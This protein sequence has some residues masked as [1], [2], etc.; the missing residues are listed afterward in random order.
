MICVAY[1]LFVLNVVMLGVVVSL[2]LVLGEIKW[3]KR[4]YLLTLTPYTCSDSKPRL[5]F[6]SHAEA[7]FCRA[8]YGATPWGR[9]KACLSNIR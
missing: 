7:Y 9:L 2:M 6:D 3:Q 1:K 5:I 8:L 4:A